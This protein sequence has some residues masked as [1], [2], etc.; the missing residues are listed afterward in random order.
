MDGPGE[1]VPDVTEGITCVDDLP[2]PKTRRCSRNYKKRPCPHCGHSAYRNKVYTRKLHDLGD[3]AANCP[4]D[5]AVTYSQ[6]YCSKCRK[7]GLRTSRTCTD[8]RR[9]G[10]SRPRSGWE[11]GGE[12]IG[13]SLS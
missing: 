7:Y 6:H 11:F 12:E 10:A 5:L 13:V 2:E 4:V 3:L 1:Y 9:G 8:A